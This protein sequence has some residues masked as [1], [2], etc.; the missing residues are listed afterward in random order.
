[1]FLHSFVRYLVIVGCSMSSSIF[2]RGLFCLGV[3]LVLSGLSGGLGKAYGGCFSW[4]Y[5]TPRNPP[6]FL[7]PVE[8]CGSGN[9]DAFNLACLNCTCQII[10]ASPGSCH[11]DN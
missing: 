9:C 11:C 3:C 7:A 2:D 1:V 4:S 5:C 6:C 8:A 10:P